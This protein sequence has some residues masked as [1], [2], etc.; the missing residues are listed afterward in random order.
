M[1]RLGREKEVLRVVADQYGC[2]TYAAD[3]ADAILKIAA[4]INDRSNIAGAFT[5][6]V[7][8]E[9]QPGMVL[10]RRYSSWQDNTIRFQ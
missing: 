1:L 2:P 6:I 3:L 7:E 5:T 8:S 9:Q 4:Q 10:Q